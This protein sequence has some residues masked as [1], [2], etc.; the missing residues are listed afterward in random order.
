MPSNPKPDP[1]ISARIRLAR[2]SRTAGRYSDAN[3]ELMADA[4]RGYTSAKLEAHIRAVLADPEPLTTGQLG[5]LAML[6]L[7]GGS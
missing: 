1:V 3:P 4:R 5:E 7:R 6:L 2:A